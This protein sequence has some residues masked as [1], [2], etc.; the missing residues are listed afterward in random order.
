MFNH[1]NGTSKSSPSFVTV[2]LQDSYQEI[3]ALLS[4]DYKTPDKTPINRLQHS[5]QGSYQKII[6]LLSRDYKT[7]DKTPIN[8]LRHT[9]QEIAALL[10][11]D[12]SK[13]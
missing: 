5:Y 7:P 9:Y 6:R 4:R 12:L 8:R 2:L 10:S 11:R 3:S 1:E 13:T